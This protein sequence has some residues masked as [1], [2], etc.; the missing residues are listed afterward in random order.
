MRDIWSTRFKPCA[1]R[2][3]C[4]R[5]LGLLLALSGLLLLGTPATKVLADGGAPNLA[6]V[7]GGAQGL[8][9]I[10]IGQQKV[11]LHITLEGNPSAIY[12]TPDGRS[13]YVAQP[14]LN[15]VTM[16]AA[17]TGTVTC[18]VKLPD[19]QPSFLAFDAGVNL[20]YA[21]GQGSS[22]I[23]ALN[24][25]S[26]TINKTIATQGPVYGLATAEVGTGP[27]GGTGNQLW[28][29]T[30]DAVNV[31]Q[32]NKIHSIPVSGNPQYLSIPPGATVYATTRQGGIVAVDLQTLHATAPIFHGGDFGPMDFDTYTSEIYVPDKAHNRVIVLTPLTYGSTTAP[33]EPNHIISFDAA[34]QA[35]AIT[36]DG[37]LGFV[38]LAGGKVA[39]LD[40][41][42]K[43]LIN[44]INVGGTPRFIITGVYPPP[45]NPSP[46]APA[47]GLQIPT[48][49]LYAMAA[50]A[51]LLLAVIG[52]LIVIAQRRKPEGPPSS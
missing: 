49:L 27:N 9:V 50:V 31:Y 36:G 5:A 15:R 28:F 10:D 13:L 30:A 45:V 24:G 6:Y 22:G 41:P 7:A 32:Q 33:S 34:P 44:T 20:L 38:A 48:T 39:M 52:A 8:S 12:L 51:L 1:W 16:L 46:A 29:T 47:N 25:N 4:P 26:C 43:T 19:L 21:A 42:G 3:L 18:T 35:I 17:S 23:T 37:N 14:G 2:M 11:T 40:I